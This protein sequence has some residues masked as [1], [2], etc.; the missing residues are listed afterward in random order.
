VSLQI[1]LVGVLRLLFPSV[2]HLYQIVN[3]GAVEIATN[4]RLE[5]LLVQRLV[6]AVVYERWED[7]F[8]DSH[9]KYIGG[10]LGCAVTGRSADEIILIHDLDR[11]TTRY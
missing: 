5:L 8:Q 1:V 7:V 10:V 2:R 11:S 3:A 6:E 4:N 9:S